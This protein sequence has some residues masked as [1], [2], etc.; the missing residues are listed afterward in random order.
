MRVKMLVTSPWLEPVTLGARPGACDGIQS[1]SRLFCVE[2]LSAVWMCFWSF[3]IFYLVVLGSEWPSAEAP[4]C[5]RSRVQISW[6]RG[7]EHARLHVVVR[8]V[9]RW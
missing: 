8:F 9:V 6:L 7:M 5:N 4:G 3:K 1:S 2:L